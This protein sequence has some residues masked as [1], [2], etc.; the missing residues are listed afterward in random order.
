[1]TYCLKRRD[2]ICPVAECDCANCF[3]TRRVDNW[4]IKN[5]RDLDK[6]LETLKKDNRRRN[7]MLIGFLIGFF[8]SLLIFTLIRALTA[9]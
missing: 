1:M 2:T 7:F 6:A 9:Q 5:D 8:G 3:E 4:R